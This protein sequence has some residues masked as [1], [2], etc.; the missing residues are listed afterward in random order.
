MSNR[1]ELTRSPVRR[2]NDGRA[3]IALSPP[4]EDYGDHQTDQ[5]AAGGD[6]KDGVDSHTLAYVG[7]AL[8]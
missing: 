3:S 5:H 2:G 6:V 8:S 7:Y 4:L 1:E